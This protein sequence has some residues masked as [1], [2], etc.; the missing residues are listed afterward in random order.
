MDMRIS[1]LNVAKATLAAPSYLPPVDVGGGISYADGSFSGNNPTLLV[2]KEIRMSQE[3]RG[4]YFDDSHFAMILNFGIGPGGFEDRLSAKTPSRA[5]STR[6]GSSVTTLRQS[7]TSRILQW[8]QDAARGEP[9]LEKKL[10]RNV[11]DEMT[12]ARELDSKPV[13]DLDDEVARA[14]RLQACKL[15]LPYYRFDA[16]HSKDAVNIQSSRWKPFNQKTLKSIY[17]W[18]KGYVGEEDVKNRIWK[19]AKQLVEHR[20][21]KINK[22]L[23]LETHPTD[24]TPSGGPNESTKDF[25]PKTDRDAQESRQSVPKERPSETGNPESEHRGETSHNAA[26]ERRHSEQQG[27]YE[28]AP[29]ANL[30]SSHNTTTDPIFNNVTSLFAWDESPHLSDDADLLS[31]LPLH[32]WDRNGAKVMNLLNSKPMPL[33]ISQAGPV[34]VFMAE[35]LAPVPHNGRSSLRVA[36]SHS[37]MHNDTMV[38]SVRQPGSSRSTAPTT[39]STLTSGPSGPSAASEGKLEAKSAHYCAEELKERVLQ[40]LQQRPND[41]GVL[42]NTDQCNHMY[43]RHL[44]LDK[45]CKQSRNTA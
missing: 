24:D 2:M 11:D 22:L 33:I 32:S 28:T 44:K 43:D 31:R 27:A 25:D 21:M 23:P 7:I 15:D 37:T 19:C 42:F 20:R 10:S 45:L 41:W 30:T 3:Q 38:S 9:T 16:W 34:V 26:V 4:K 17:L 35:N 6:T 8:R 36:T 5:T 39:Y 18:I 1:I 40:V 12:K 29:L 13:V 14:L